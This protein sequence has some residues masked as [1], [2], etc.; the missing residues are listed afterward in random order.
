M[1]LKKELNF[2]AVFSIATGAMIS[3]GIFILPGLAFAR[4]GPAVIISYFLAGIL[5]L[6][7]IFSI[8]EL[9]TAIPKAG[10]DYYFINRS[11]GPLIGTISGFFSWFALSLKSAFAIFGIAEI[12]FVTTGFPVLISSIFVT[13][14]FVFLNIMGVKEAAKFQMIL[15]SGLLLLMIL[16]VVSGFSK[17]N[18][19]H[20]VPFLS[21]G[22]NPIFATAGF[23]FISFGGLLNVASI[24]EEVSNPKKSIPLGL[25]VSVITVTVIYTAVLIV[26]TGV[27]EASE[28]AGSLTPIADAARLII[29]SPGFILISLAAMLA[30]V[31]TANAGIMSASRYPLALSR[32][33]LLPEFISHVNTRFKTPVR[34]IAITGLFIITALLLPLEML[35]KAASVVILTSYVLTNLSVI[36]LR[37]SKLQNYRPSFKAPLYP[38][39][40]IGSIFIFL[41]FI[42]D[43]GVEAIEITL[44]FLIISLLV[45][46]LYGKKKFQIEYALLHLLRKITDG[47]LQNHLLESEFRDILIERDNIQIDRFDELVRQASILDLPG[48]ITASELFHQ[49]SEHIARE[50]KL[51]PDEI[52]SLLQ[53]RQRDTNTAISEF[54]AIPH[55]II[56]GK[57]NFCLIIVRC[58]DGIQFTE[59]ENAVKAVFAFVGT[60]E[61]RT[62]H[63]RTLASIAALAQQQDFEEKWLKA[64][65][66]HYLRDFVLLSNRFR[67]KQK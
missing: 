62:F 57:D 9:S 55:I 24:S 6:I 44:V 46:F 67:F 20:F 17:I 26:T 25:I 18:A 52:F 27:L 49:I 61:E 32:D 39:L 65:D 42:V 22:L 63:L 34:S 66:T 36:I 31:T 23:I 53:A 58:K 7:G 21:D 45:Y 28:F 64:K 14:I 47:K 10:G 40:Q 4:T 51:N 12:I 56:E 48:P 2:F 30:F 35:V 29:G 8:V 59:K 13:V 41:F 3:S 11:L 54:I 37:E 1:K 43:L 19:G 60:K 16:F 5:A 38:W 33:N 50:T 15:V